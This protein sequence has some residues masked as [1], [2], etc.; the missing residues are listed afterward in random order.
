MDFQYILFDLDGT[1]TDSAIGII[2]SAMYALNKLGIEL[3]NKGVLYKFIG[4]PLHES[5][6]KYAG[7]S[8]AEAKKGVEYYRE[9]YKVTG[10]FENIVYEG[11]EDLLKLLKGKKKSIILATSKPEIYA[12]QILEHFNLA[13][14]FDY[15]A[16]SELDGRRTKKDE[17]ISYALE[18]YGISDLSKVIMIGDR[19]ND[20]IGAKKAGVKSLGVLYG[21]GDRNELETA[22]ADFIVETVDELIHFFA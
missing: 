11:I 3:E 14:Y 21:Y 18:S 19:E 5:F 15:I 1:V 7:F 12:K 16:G 4:P 17:V 6:Q 9:Y 20:I 8:E 10:I 2:K 22:G 13:A